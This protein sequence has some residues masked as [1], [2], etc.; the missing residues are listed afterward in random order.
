MKRTRF[1]P[2][3]IF[4]MLAGVLVFGHYVPAK[5]EEN[6]L[7]AGEVGSPDTFDDFQAENISISNIENGRTL[8]SIAADRVVHRKRVSRF[9]VYQN[10]KEL[11]LTGARINIFQ[12]KHALQT[13]HDSVSLP[14]GDI[15]GSFMSFG[16]PA[17]SM[18]SYLAGIPDAD[19]DILSRVLF[20]DLSI[21]IDISVGRKISFRAGR[22]RINLDFENIIFDGPLRIVD[23]AGTELTAQLGVWT[24]KHNGIYLPKGFVFKGD[25]YNGEGFYALNGKGEFFRGRRL[26]K[27]NYMDPLDDR[28]DFINEYILGKVPLTL[29]V[30]LGLYR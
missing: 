6:T 9:F 16:K 30:M 23:A 8:F 5:N 12:V 20:E 14:L 29:R 17:T 26:P 28:E 27:V 3:F 19:L 7:E 24:N 22:A 25:I 21:A 15:G 1:L 18:E 4:M 10:L 11:C 2:A 13:S